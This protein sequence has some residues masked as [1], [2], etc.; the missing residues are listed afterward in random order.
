MKIS[1][2][3]ATTLALVAFARISPAMAD[4][5]RPSGGNAWPGMSQRTETNLVTASP[6]YELQ[7][8]YA[9]RHPRWVGQWVLVR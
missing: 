5:P 6:H 1:A 7:Y 2:L 9:G 3:G 4:G 8:H